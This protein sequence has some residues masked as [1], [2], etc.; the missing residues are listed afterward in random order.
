MS[1]GTCH[2][3][4]IAYTFF[5]GPVDYRNRALSFDTEVVDV[6]DNLQ[7]SQNQVDA[8]IAPTIRLGIK[9]AAGSDRMQFIVFSRSGRKNISRPVDNDIAPCLSAPFAKQIPGRPIFVGQCQ[10][11]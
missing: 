11:A 2:R 7:A 3:L 6:P 1:A 10:T 4:R 9:V 8:V 5:Y